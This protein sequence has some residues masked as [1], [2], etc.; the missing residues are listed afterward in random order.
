MPWTAMGAFAAI[1]SAR[2]SAA[3]SAPSAWTSRFTRPQ[4]SAVAASIGRPA[5]KSS[6]VRAAPTSPRNRRS[7]PSG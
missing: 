5:K 6:R 2:A 3:A 4:P 7:P 1:S